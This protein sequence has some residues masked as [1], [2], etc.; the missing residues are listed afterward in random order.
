MSKKCIM[1]FLGIFLVFSATLPT[2]IVHGHAYDVTGQF[3]TNFLT[4]VIGFS[5]FQIVSF[6][7]TTGSTM[8]GSE[9]VET[10]MQLEV[11]VN[12]D[13][14]VASMLLEDGKLTMFDLTSPTTQFSGNETFSNCL[15]VASRTVRQYGET[16]NL[17]YGDTFA[18]MIPA[19]LNNSKFS[20][21]N[22]DTVLNA[23]CVA[24]CSTPEDYR[25]YTDL[26]WAKRINNTNF[27]EFL[28]ICVSKN[29]LVTSI[30]DNMDLY[31][32]ASTNITVSEE[33]AEVIANSIAQNYAQQHGQRVVSVNASLTWLRDIDMF[34]G[35]DFAIYPAWGVAITFD[36]VN[37]ESVSWYTVGIWA[38]NGQVFENDPQGV[39]TFLNGGN[40]ANGPALW[41]ARANEGS[42]HCF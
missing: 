25:R 33:E 6:N 23:S 30:S 40:G 12:N 37:N 42:S 38:D 1:A 11:T 36:K 29:G 5:N 35:D 3:A 14:F 41:I 21:E 39:D 22:G 16:L 4:K 20:A 34:R 32:V 26:Q 7:S 24:N 19:A 8:T 15:A 28:G 13:T 18:E 10:P 9:H 27:E 31:Y 17:T 2:T